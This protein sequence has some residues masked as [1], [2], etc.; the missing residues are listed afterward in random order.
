MT[1]NAKSGAEG[2]IDRIVRQRFFPDSGKDRVFVDVGAASP[3]YLSISAYYRALGWRIIAIEPNPVFCQLHKEKGHEVLQYA[4][5]ERDEDNVDF[6]VVDS[7]GTEYADGR[8]S[9]ESFSS[10]GIKDSYSTLKE[11]LDI[12]KIKVNLRRLDT[13]LRTHAR[14]VDRIDILSI[15]VEGWELEVLNGLDIPRYRPRVMI[16]ENLFNAREY[17]SYMKSIGYVLWKRIP[18]NEVYVSSELI[19]GLIRWWF[20]L[21][22]P[23]VVARRR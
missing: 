9:Y 5:G 10:L 6:L 20:L 11:G 19:P 13:I 8:V 21:F 15:D 18:P 17:W 14:D 12:K 7:H 23:L 4:C 2:N 16:I 1:H 3:D 22:Y